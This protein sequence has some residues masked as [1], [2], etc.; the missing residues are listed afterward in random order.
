MKTVI[1]LGNAR[2]GTSMV[3]GF[4][5]HL[6][7]DM[8]PCHNPSVQNPKG[9]YEDQNLVQ[10]TTDVWIKKEGSIDFLNNYLRKR[11]SLGKDWGFKSGLTHEVWEHIDTSIFENLY[12]ICNSRSILMNAKSW[13]F[14]MKY[15]YGDT[16]RTLEEAILHTQ[17]SHNT[18]FELTSKLQCKKMYTC[19]EQVKNDPMKV[20]K[21]IADF[22]EIQLNEDVKMFA[23]NFIMSNYST[24]RS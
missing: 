18:L 4:V 2:S 20:I 8:N 5:H 21:E 17:R 11:V 19:Y 6:G 14:H 12:I 22:L 3:S 1:I 10:Y 24:L 9:S 13:L 16:S 7:V 23:S 15:N